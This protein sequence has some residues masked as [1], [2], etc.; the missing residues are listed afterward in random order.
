VTKTDKKYAKC[1]SKKDIPLIKKKQ[2]KN[3]HE[4]KRE[5]KRSALINL[6]KKFSLSP[7]AKPGGGGEPCVNEKRNRVIGGQQPLKGRSKASP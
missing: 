1:E 3:A 4:K 6:E 5:A 2:R 7:R